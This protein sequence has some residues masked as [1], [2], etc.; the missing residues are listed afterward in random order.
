MYING[1]FDE[2]L[3]ETRFANQIREVES[4]S[5]RDEDFI[6]LIFEPGGSNDG[7][8]AF[9]VYNALEGMTPNK[10][11]DERIWTALTHSVG[12][13]FSK[14]RWLVNLTNREKILRS[15]KS[16]FFRSRRQKRIAQK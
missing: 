11:K 10:A 15:I 7:K 8:N 12:F 1:G 16:H 3:A 13:E 5:I 4:I 9:I 14:N 2:L 6:N